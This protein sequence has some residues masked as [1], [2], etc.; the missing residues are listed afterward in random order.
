LY[1]GN[2]TIF[3]ITDDNALVTLGGTTTQVM[4]SG[5]ISGTSLVFSTSSVSRTTGTIPFRTDR[6]QST[7]T[8]TFTTLTGSTNIGQST[9]SPTGYNITTISYDRNGTPSSTGSTILFHSASTF[10]QP[11]LSQSLAYFGSAQGYDGGSLTGTSETFSGETYRLQITD[12][13]LSGS[14]T[15][16]DKFTTGSYSAYSLT[17]KD[18]QVKPGY[19][20][21]PGGTY[22]YWLPN[23]GTEFKYYARAFNTNNANQINSFI[24]GLT[25]STGNVIKWNQTAID[26][27]ACLVICSNSTGLNNAIDIKEDSLSTQT[28]T[29]GTN[30]T[31]PFGSNI[32][33]Y[34]NTAAYPTVG[35]GGVFLLDGSNR[36]YVVLVR[37]RGDVGPITNL[38]ITY[39]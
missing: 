12:K 7:N 20:V 39:P 17:S 11:P 3:N 18:L 38:S 5:N 27:V 37:M 33:V 16:G 21:R 4:S 32:T 26:G 24:L 28:F 35:V 15:I 22:G 13:L 31:N 25:L 14:Y 36:N 10:G 6:L 34:K 19:L 8:A 29:A 2:S 23:D 1:Y 30:G 9:V